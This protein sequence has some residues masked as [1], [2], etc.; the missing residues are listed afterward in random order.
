MAQ[1]LMADLMSKQFDSEERGTEDKFFWGFARV[2][3]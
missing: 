1:P 3:R 2:Y